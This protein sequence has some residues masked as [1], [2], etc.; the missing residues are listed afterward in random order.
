[1]KKLN[2]ILLSITFAAGSLSVANA[3]WSVQD[4]NSNNIKK[5]TDDL[6]KAAK[7]QISNQEAAKS[8]TEVLSKQM[9]IQ[10]EETDKRNR[11]NIALADTVKR[12]R[13]AM[14]TLKQ[15]VDLTR[16]NV[17]GG[18]SKTA[19]S[20]GGGASGKDTTVPGAPAYKKAQEGA[21][22]QLRKLGMSIET[23]KAASACG[24]TEMEKGS[25]FC[26]EDAGV[27]KFNGANI[28]PR[29]LM[30]N[31][32]DNENRSYKNYT[33]DAEAQKAALEYIKVSALN[34][35]P[36]II[37]K[38]KVKSN[39]TY[40]AN[41]YIVTNGIQTAADAMTNVT[42]HYNEI[43]KPTE[44]NGI[45]QTYW[46]KVSK[47][48]ELLDM[49]KPK[50]PSLAEMYILEVNKDYYMLDDEKDS[51]GTE[52]EQLKN[53]NRKMA[54]ANYLTARQ[55]NLQEYQNILMSHLV[56]KSFE[57]DARVL[58]KEASQINGVKLPGEN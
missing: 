15:C 3:Q 19:R 52:I 23:A 32:K 47:A 43:D 16:G 4:V 44:A 26:G 54:L 7:T 33:L 10:L 20:G 45:F 1:M 8:A 2:K 25:K 9:S 49:E 39:E 58:T 53:L 41:Y 38:D 11:S 56:V 37:H 13:D 12:D 55:I 35:L 36:P 57:Q 5:N 30:G 29:S 6:V 46:T 24:T 28:S 22:S 21:K 17:A 51:D 48:Y 31:Y 34:H 18:G 40:L 14:P 50:T 27:S 42:S